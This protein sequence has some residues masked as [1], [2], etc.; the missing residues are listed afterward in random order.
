MFFT[1][2]QPLLDVDTIKL[3]MDVFEKNNNCI[4][5]PIHENRKGSPVIFPRRFINELKLLQG[6]NGGK[7]VINNH[8]N[9]VITVDVRNEYAMV[10]IDTWQ[11]YEKITRG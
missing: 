6:D 7:N 1:S 11:D 8:A 2:D 5:V 4:V 9:N 3:L 10:D